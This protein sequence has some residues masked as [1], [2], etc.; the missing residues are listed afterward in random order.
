MHGDGRCSQQPV[1]YLELPGYDFWKET[2]QLSITSAMIGWT[3]PLKVVFFVSLFVSRKWSDDRRRRR[4]DARKKRLF[5]TTNERRWWW[6]CR[7]SSVSSELKPA[8]SEMLSCDITPPQPVLLTVYT[9]VCQVRSLRY[10]L[11]GFACELQV[12]IRVVQQRVE[13]GIL[14]KHSNKSSLLI[15]TL[16]TTPFSLSFGILHVFFFVFLLY[17]F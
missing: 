10:L 4:R 11:V 15:M 9:H 8:D 7:L 12:Q 14:G 1:D 5:K 16:K 6:C 13:Q 17:I 2:S 3:V